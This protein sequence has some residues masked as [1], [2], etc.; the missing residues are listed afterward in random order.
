MTR[1][2]WGVL[3]VLVPTLAGAQVPI[4][5]HANFEGPVSFSGTLTPAALAGNVDDYNPTGLATA[6]TLRLDGGAADR[7]LTGIQ[8]GVN[9]RLLTVVN[10]GTTNS[11]I[12]ATD[13]TSTAA[14]RF[15]FPA[16][17][18]LA[19]NNAVTLRYDA[20]TARWRVLTAAG[21]ATGGTG[22]VT[23]VGSCT[24]PACFTAGAPA[25]SLTFNNATS[26]TVTLQTVTGALGTRTVSLPA[27]TGTVCTTGSVCTGYQA[28]ITN[29]VT[30]TG[31]NTHLA[32]WTGTNSIGDTNYILSGATVAR[33][34]TFPDANSTVA[35]LGTA[36]TFTAAHTFQG[37]SPLV[38]NTA[39][40]T[41]DQVAFN[42]PTGGAARF[43]GTFQPPDLTANRTYTLPNADSTLVVPDAG[44]ANNFLTAISS[45]GAI[46][47]AQPSIASLSDA[48]NVAKLDTAN[49]W[50]DGIK[51]TFNPSGTTAGLNV[52]SVAG[53]PGTPANGDLWYD[54][55][56]NELT[57]RINGANVAL[58]AGGSG[59]P[60]GTADGQVQYRATSTTF[61]GSTGMTLDADAILTQKDKCTAVSGATTLG[62]HNCLYVTTG[63][64]GVT[65]TLPAASSGV[66]ARRYRIYKV[67][68]GVGALTLARTGGDT[69]NGVGSNLTTSVQREG[70]VIQEAGATDW[71]VERVLTSVPTSLLA[72]SAKTKTCLLLL[73]SAESTATALAN[74]SDENDACVNNTGANGTVT[75]VACHA[76]TATGTPSVDVKQTSTAGSSILTGAISC[77]TGWTAGTLSGTPALNTFSGTGMATCSSAPCQLA[78]DVTPGGTAKKIAVKIVWSLP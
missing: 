73:G 17:I 31:V 72:A 34:Y 14:N 36:Q 10:V 63:A 70:F 25:A 68:A 35:V 2:V 37:A 71:L 58:G 18:T 8:G 69:I 44:T 1:W 50:A 4:N 38:V 45:T 6:Q 26:G 67:D 32:A 15:L 40:A 23:D 28:S 57:A 41:D 13:T 59:S 66:N 64:G 75:A 3:L 29:P 30:G 49:A 62:A 47:K 77:G 61:G 74:D 48:T 27:E 22:D 5:P 39:T 43:T 78:V 51:Q 16:S 20:T 12:L 19:P 33:T 52:G 55:T 56:A 21:T 46:S 7:T 76:D 54:S 42:V 9:G 24:G 53:D 60:G 65:I 11:L